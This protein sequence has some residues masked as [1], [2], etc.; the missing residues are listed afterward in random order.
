VVNGTAA[1]LEDETSTWIKAMDNHEKSCPEDN[2][3]PQSR[4][5][6]GDPFD[7]PNLKPSDHG[8]NQ[9]PAPS[10]IDGGRRTKKFLKTGNAH[11]VVAREQADG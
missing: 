2:H 4:S 1:C 3:R 11:E 10:G 6:R 9:P 7:K 8:G 5:R